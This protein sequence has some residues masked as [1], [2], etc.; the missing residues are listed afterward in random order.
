MCT[1]VTQSLAS[2]FNLHVCFLSQISL[3]YVD[4]FTTCLI[5]VRV[6]C[7]VRLLHLTRNYFIAINNDDNYNSNNGTFQNATGHSTIQ[8]EPLQTS[9]DLFMLQ[10]KN[11]GNLKS[12]H[13]FESL[14]TYL[15]DF[16]LYTVYGA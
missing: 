13:Q 7:P 5:A 14:L 10:A 1:K 6:S 3:A 15:N 4:L 9:H 2:C 8:Q 12:E 11:Q 16:F